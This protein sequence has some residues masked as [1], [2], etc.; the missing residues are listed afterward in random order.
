MSFLMI[1]NAH[2]LVELKMDSL[3]VHPMRRLILPSVSTVRM[4]SMKF[5][6]MGSVYASPTITLKVGSVLLVL[7]LFAPLVQLL[8]A[9]NVWIKLPKMPMDNVNVM[10]EHILKITNVSIV[11][12]VVKS[13]HQ[14]NNAQCVLM[15]LMQMELRL[16]T[17]IRLTALVWKDSMKLTNL[18]VLSAKKDV[19]VALI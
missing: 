17:L 13:A 2:R 4:L 19:L 8:F 10:L 14:K 1:F 12:Q 18:F 16:E 3:P 5:I 9:L 6:W 7:C 15:E 11:L